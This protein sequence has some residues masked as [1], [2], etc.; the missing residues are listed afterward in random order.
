MQFWHKRRRRSLAEFFRY[1]RNYHGA[2]GLGADCT[3]KIVDRARSSFESR[4]QLDT[5]TYSFST[6]AFQQGYSSMTVCIL[7]QNGHLSPAIA[8]IYCT[9]TALALACHAKTVFTDPGSIPK[10][11]IPIVSNDTTSLVVHS[12]CS[13]CK[14]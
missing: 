4:E 9:I 13:Q 11:A 5:F 6:A 1:C 14:S 3:F 7:C 10:Q 8:A 12:I 2:D